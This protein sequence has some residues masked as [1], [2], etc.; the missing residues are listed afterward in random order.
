MEVGSC[1]LLQKQ[2]NEIRPAEICCLIHRA[3]A[4]I[5]SRIYMYSRLKIESGKSEMNAGMIYFCV[6]TTMQHLI[7]IRFAPEVSL[8]GSRAYANRYSVLTNH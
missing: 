2:D 3:C 6:K 8:R 1:A 7:L 5:N 4:N